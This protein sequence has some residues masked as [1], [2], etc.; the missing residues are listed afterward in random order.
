MTTNNVA[1]YQECL[2]ALRSALGHG[3]HVGARKRAY[4]VAA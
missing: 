4:N 1:E 3:H 2:V